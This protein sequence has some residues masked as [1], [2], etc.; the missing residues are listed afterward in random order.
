MGFLSL[1][2]IL[3]GGGAHLYMA[4]ATPAEL[5]GPGGWHGN[6]FLESQCD[7]L[8]VFLRLLA[9]CQGGTGQDGVTVLQ[10]KQN[11][12]FALEGGNFKPALRVNQ[13]HGV[14]AGEGHP[15]RR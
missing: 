2:A 12:G 6:F 9:W 7:Y 4:G 11:L 15:R 8:L 10:Y 13:Y 14:W 3:R 5:T 1:G